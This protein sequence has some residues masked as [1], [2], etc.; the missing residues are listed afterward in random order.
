MMGRTAAALIAALSILG[1]AQARTPLP[2]V[3]TI[4]EGLGFQYLPSALESRCLRSV[5]NIVADG[6]EF[7]VPADLKH[8]GA[9]CRSS[10]RRR[11]TRFVPAEN[12]ASAEDG[13]YS[14][15]FQ[16]DRCPDRVITI[17]FRANAATRYSE[18]FRVLTGWRACVLTR[19]NTYEC[20]PYDPELV[21]ARTTE[22]RT[23]LPQP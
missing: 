11:A 21:A 18:V 7:V 5:C 16:S 3:S 17:R 13:A 4:V 9:W 22:I 23:V 20:T 8:Q 1:S 6:V 14:F 12:F 19:N 10:S 2:Q 15:R